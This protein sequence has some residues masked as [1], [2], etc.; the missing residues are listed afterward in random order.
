MREKN[1]KN[2]ILH[3]IVKN[4][5][6]VPKIFSVICLTDMM[7]YAIVY[8]FGTNERLNRAHKYATLKGTI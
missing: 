8:M 7:Q 6:L 4:R 1:T 2:Y 3:F 5:I